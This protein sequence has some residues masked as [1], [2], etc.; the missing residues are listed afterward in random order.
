MTERLLIVEDD[1]AVR[2]MLE[3]S[4]GAEGFESPVP[5][6]AAPRWRS[7][8]APRRTWSSSTWRCRG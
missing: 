5:P 3:R 6:T 7:P 4:L 2:R 8:N 1:A